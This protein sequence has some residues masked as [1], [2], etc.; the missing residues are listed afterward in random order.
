MSDGVGA[1]E[2]IGLAEEHEFGVERVGVFDLLDTTKP[3]DFHHAATI[4]EYGYE[5]L[6]CTLSFFIKTQKSPFDLLI[7]PLFVLR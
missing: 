6:L 2:E 5:A 4:G 3:Y 1:F 7:F